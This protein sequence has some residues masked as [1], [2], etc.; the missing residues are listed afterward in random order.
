MPARVIGLPKT[1]TYRSERLRRA[2]ASLPCVNCGREGLTQAAHANQ[3]KGMGIKGSDARIMALCIYC[4]A[5]HD[6]GGTRTKEERRR[7]ED[8]M[9]ARTYVALMEAERLEVVG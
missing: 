7:F 8:E 4:H 1:L 5:E 2:V 3:G 6:Q 9:V